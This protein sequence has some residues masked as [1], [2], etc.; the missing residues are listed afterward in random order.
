MPCRQR[1]FFLSLHSILARPFY[2]RA[3]GRGGRRE[4]WKEFALWQAPRGVRRPAPQDGY[5][6]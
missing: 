3:R 4:L 5:V 6:G 1:L 2:R